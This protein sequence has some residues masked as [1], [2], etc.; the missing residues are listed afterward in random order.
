MLVVCSGFVEALGWKNAAALRLEAGSFST[1]TTPKLSP[2][3]RRMLMLHEEMGEMRRSLGTRCDFE[4]RCSCWEIPGITTSLLCT[5][6]VGRTRNRSVASTVLCLW[7]SL[8]GDA[9]III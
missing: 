6:Q 9:Y 2:A 4:Y 8:L 7:F 5:S 1:S 3:W